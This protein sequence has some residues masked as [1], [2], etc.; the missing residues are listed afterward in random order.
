MGHQAYK[1]PLEMAPLNYIRNSTSIEITD[2][3]EIAR[4][5]REEI[6]LG[7]SINRPVDDSWTIFC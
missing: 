6:A 4:L 2:E 3:N 1:T 7:E 5:E